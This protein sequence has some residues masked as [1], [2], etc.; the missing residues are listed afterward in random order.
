MNSLNFRV[1]TIIILIVLGCTSGL[2]EE[3]LPIF[4][5]LDIQERKVEDKIVYDTLYHTIGSFA[6]L[7]QDSTMITNSDFRN[8]IYV[9]DFFFTSCLSIC[10]IMKTQMLRIYEEFDEDENVAFLS[11]STD[12]KHDT[13]AVLRE[14]AERLG[15]R[16]EKWH[17]VTGEKEEIYKLAQNSYMSVAAEDNEAPG[18]FIHSSRFLLVDKEGRIR[19]VYDGTDPLDVDEL[20]KDISVL[21]NEYK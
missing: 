8:K 2:K 7:D 15:V 21:L 19:G 10:P 17:F 4:G 3:V 1:F 6:F 9:A 18:G 12:P 20:I 14:Y 5:R 13:V 16:S 11:H